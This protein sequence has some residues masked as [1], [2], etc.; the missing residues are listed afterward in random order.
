M[1]LTHWP[2]NET[3]DWG[4]IFSAMRRPYIFDTH[5]FLAR[6]TIEKIGFSYDGLGI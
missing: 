1:L 5:N 4:K 6:E 2:Q 3:L